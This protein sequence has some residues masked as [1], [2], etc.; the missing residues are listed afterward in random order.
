MTRQKAEDLARENSNRDTC[1]IYNVIEVDDYSYICRS[2]LWCER[3]PGV[4]VVAQY[5]KGSP[6]DA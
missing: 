2:E 5:L 4:M 6:V 1:T 3:H